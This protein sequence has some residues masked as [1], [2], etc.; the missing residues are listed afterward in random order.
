MR[1]Q[2]ARPGTRVRVREAYWKSDLEG[3]RGI[4]EA[5]WGDPSYLVLGVRLEDGRSQLFWF[6][7]LEMAQEA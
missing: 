6:H 2:E 1:P 7:P 3:M 4:I 5:R